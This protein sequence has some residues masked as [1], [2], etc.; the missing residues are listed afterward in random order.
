MI[1]VLLASALVS[2]LAMTQ[3]KHLM[4]YGQS[5]NHFFRAYYLSKGALELAL[6]EIATREVGFEIASVQTG[7]RIVA[8][9]LSG[10]GQ[11]PFPYWSW[12]MKARTGSQQVFLQSGEHLTI[13]LFVDTAHTHLKAL[14]EAFSLDSFDFINDNV[15]KLSLS[16]C[17]PSSSSVELP[18]MVSIFSYQGS[19]STGFVQ[20]YA[21]HN[22]SDIWK[23]SDVDQHLQSVSQSNSQS[24]PLSEEKLVKTYL[25]IFNQSPKLQCVEVSWENKQFGLRE[26]EVW[27][28]GHY[29]NTEV[30]MRAS[31]SETP[32][33]WSVLTL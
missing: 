24:Q 13:P 10:Y 29:G 18:F 33:S 9:N 26:T 16:S 14:S 23:L 3:L 4:S 8:K 17:S 28:L 20:A 21:Q 2:L 12:T 19:S 27:S 15:K 22:M 11:D 32:P 31:F 1:F 30:G 5:T 6:A 25:T 7:E